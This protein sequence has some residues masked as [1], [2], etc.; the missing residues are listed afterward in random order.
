M[1][2][3]IELIPYFGGILDIGTWIQNSIK[4]S[5]WAM[6]NDKGVFLWPYHE[7]YHKILT[8]IMKIE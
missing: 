1:F 6:S 7:P 3:S 8:R 5:V 2:S 4:N